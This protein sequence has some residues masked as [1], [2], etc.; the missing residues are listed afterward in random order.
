ME[1]ESKKSTRYYSVLIGLLGACDSPRT[2]GV[3][4]VSD[5]QDHAASETRQEVAE[6]NMNTGSGTEH[7][8]PQ[9]L[10]YIPEEYY[11]AESIREP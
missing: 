3:T 9:E 11:Q 8:V 4:S 7:P 5:V 10:E 6:G 2:E 1:N